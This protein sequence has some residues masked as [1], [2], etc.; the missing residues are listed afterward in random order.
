M[1][2][3]IIEIKEH[4]Y[5]LSEKLGYDV[6]YDYAMKDWCTSGHAKRWHDSYLEH[7]SQ[8]EATC[9]DICH[10]NCKNGLE[11][12]LLSNEQLHKILED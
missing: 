11:N 8:L 7:L 3:Q 6:G 2:L 12:C 9:E 1:S 4:K 10:G 5:Y